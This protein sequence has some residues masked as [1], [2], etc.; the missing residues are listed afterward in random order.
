MR[1]V[2]EIQGPHCVFLILP[3]TF[4]SRQANE[5]SLLVPLDL[6]AMCPG[7]PSD[8]ERRNYEKVA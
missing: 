2:S 4:G 7:E 3:G 5:R 6:G 8:H 1:G